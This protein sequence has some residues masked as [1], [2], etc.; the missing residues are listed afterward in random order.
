MWY[1]LGGAQW[2][3]NV[4]AD[5]LAGGVRVGAIL[6]RGSP[7]GVR[8]PATVTAAE[9]CDHNQ[10]QQHTQKL[11]RGW[12]RETPKTARRRRPVTPKRHGHFRLSIDCSP[13]RF[14][15]S[16]HA[17]SGSA[18]QCILRTGSRILPPLTLRSQR[19]RP[20]PRNCSRCGRVAR[21]HLDGAIW[22]ECV[23]DH[24]PPFAYLYKAGAQQQPT[25]HGSPCRRWTRLATQ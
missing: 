25:S 21:T 4:P 17:A 8:V 16:P 12:C 22:P 6:G 14:P 9:T 19:P 7:R 24:G 1:T 3:L 20:P 10:Q 18:P 23:A 2:R 13:V 11:T 5:H 15:D